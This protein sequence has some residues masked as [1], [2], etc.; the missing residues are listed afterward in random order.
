MFFK[1]V[2]Y[3]INPLNLFKREKGAD[4]NLR[5]MHGVNKISFLVFTA[6]VIYMIVRY[7]TR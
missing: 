7:A 6:C 4:T 1:K 3:Y 5:L 2:L